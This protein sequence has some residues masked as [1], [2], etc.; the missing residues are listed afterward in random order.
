MRD[1]TPPLTKRLSA[2]NAIRNRATNFLG[3]NMNA[4]ELSIRI[5]EINNQIESSKARIANFSSKKLHGTAQRIIENKIIELK[6]LII[7][8]RTE[9]IKVMTELC[10]ELGATYIP[11]RGMYA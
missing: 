8:L 6:G 9:H 3:D 4:Y 2:S 7:S 10:N 11:N 5:T 1:S